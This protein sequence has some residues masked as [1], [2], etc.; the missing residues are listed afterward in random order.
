MSIHQLPNKIEC[1]IQKSSEFLISKQSDRGYWNDFYIKGMGM[2]SQWVTAYIAYNLSKLSNTDEYV[3]KA[4]IWLLRTKYSSGGWGYHENCLPDS[5]ST[6]NVIRLLAYYLKKEKILTQ[7]NLVSYLYKFGDF[8]TTYQDKNTGGFATYLPVTNRTFHTMPGSA[9]CISEPSV[10]SMA[11][12]AFLN[13]DSKYFEQ[14]LLKAKEYL[15]S[16]QNPSGY[17]DSYWWDCNVYGTSLACIFLKQL[18]EIES[19]TKAI[20]WLKSI[21]IPSK[22]WGNGYENTPYP[23]Y[24]ALSLSSIL[25]CENDIH[26]RE[27]KDA[28]SWLIEIQNE[29]GSWFSKPIL[30]NPDPQVT[31]PWS[32]SYRKKCEVSTDIN[33]LFTTATVMNALQDYLNSCSYYYRA[34]KE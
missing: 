3:Q 2:S 23:F 30:R 12:L 29:D 13:L 5:D 4:I 24:T 15:I 7:E 21:F 19:V 25:L 1:A 20:S 11:G 9:W 31:E 32:I 28:V 34:S 6:A 8:L 14:E 27:V 16:R 18:G 10:T 26:S 22:G 33:L 17:W